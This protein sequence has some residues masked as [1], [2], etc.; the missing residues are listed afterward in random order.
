M[1]GGTLSNGKTIPIDFWASFFGMG[2][3]KLRDAGFKGEYFNAA[4]GH[5]GMW[6]LGLDLDFDVLEGSIYYN[7][8][9]YDSSSMNVLKFA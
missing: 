3:E 5:Q 4:G 7:H 2:S 9:F 1:M 8:P 6:D